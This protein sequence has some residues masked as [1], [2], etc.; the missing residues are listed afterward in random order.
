MV[1]LENH[2]GLVTINCFVCPVTINS[3]RVRR[4]M[5]HTDPIVSMHSWT[6]AKQTLWYEHRI[7]I[8]IF[9][10][11]H[12]RTTSWWNNRGLW[13]HFLQCC[14][15]HTR[16]Y[17][18]GTISM[19]SMKV[20]LRKLKPLAAAELHDWVQ[21]DWW[22]WVLFA[23]AFVGKLISGSREVLHSPQLHTLYGTLQGI[24]PVKRAML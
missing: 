3:C 15:L 22:K 21:I 14:I 2:E 7:M 13:I 24:I 23:A 17:W 16:F 8:I 18:N 19:H 1:N 6:K 5:Y 12:N 10:W 9:I 20:L 11:N 4:Y